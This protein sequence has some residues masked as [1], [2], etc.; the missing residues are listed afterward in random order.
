MSFQSSD[1]FMHTFSYH[2]INN[3][4]KKFIGVKWTFMSIFV[5]TT[6]T[7]D[8]HSDIFSDKILLEGSL[9]WHA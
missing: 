8:T 3:G 1:G 6:K 7:K 4:L 9:R 2:I 5:I